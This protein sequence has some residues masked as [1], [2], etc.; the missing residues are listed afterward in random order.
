MTTMLHADASPTTATAA[1]PGRAVAV[2]APRGGD[3]WVMA[4]PAAGGPS[5]LAASEPAMRLQDHRT[6]PGRAAL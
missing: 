2:A 1:L 3:A 6:A 5:W 4:Y